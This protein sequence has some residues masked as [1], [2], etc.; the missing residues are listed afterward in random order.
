MTFSL[1]SIVFVLI[2]LT[3]SS[4]GIQFDLSDGM[5][6]CIHDHFKKDD[7]VQGEYKIPPV[8]SMQLQ[9][10]IENPDRNRI[11]NVE[12]GTLGTFAFAAD[13]DGEYDFC[14]LDSLR[15]GFPI[16][17]Q[18]RRVT[19]TINLKE[20]QDL[21]DVANK[22]RLKPLEQSLKRAEEVSQ[23]IKEEM[24]YMREREAS[25]RD[26]NEQANARVAWLSVFTITVVISSTLFQAY[27]LR[28]YFQRKKLL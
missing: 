27:Y 20:K 2:F 8:P 23:S 13:L 21:Q 5:P 12:D 4:V 9:F 11:H 19:I 10:W 16:V 18:E 3:V 24:Q 17:S 25:H 22:E 1:L 26:T 15:P 14:F 28:S 7:V 6:R